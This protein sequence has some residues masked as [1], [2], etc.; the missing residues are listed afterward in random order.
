MDTEQIEFLGMNP[1]GFWRR[2]GAAFLDGLLFGLP[3]SL[4]LSIILGGEE[5]E[6]LIEVI[7]FLYFLLLP[8]FWNGYTIGKKIMGIR[9]VKMNGENVGIGNMLLREL[10]GRLIYIIT[11]GIGIIVSAIMVAAREDK[12]SIHDLIAGTYVTSNEP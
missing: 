2:F 7:T 5:N 8:L 6:Y 3:L 1:V 10:V 12:R 9:I 11:F 4:L